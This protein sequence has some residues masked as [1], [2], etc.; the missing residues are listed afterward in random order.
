MSN[1]A[2][3]QQQRR[4]T[5]LAEPDPM[6]ATLDT[7]AMDAQPAGVQP[8]FAMVGANQG[9]HTGGDI[10]T[11]QRVAVPRNNAKIM[12]NLKALAAAAGKNYVYGWKVKDRQNN[13]E[14]WIEGPT[15]K[16]A[17]DLA[18]VYGNCMVNV[19]VV[20]AGASWM[21]Y[22]RFVD[23]ETGFTTERAYQQ[24][25][26]Q[27]VGMTDD[28][29]AA[30]MIFQIGQSKCIRN[31]I[32]NALQTYADYCVD[33]AKSSL[34]D[35]VGKEPEKARTWI[36]SKIVALGIDQKRVEAI[37]GRT[38]EHWTVP[39]MARIYTELTSIL[40]GMMTANEVYP[41][42]AADVAAEDP[43]KNAAAKTGGRQPAKKAGPDNAP[44]PGQAGGSQAQE[45]KGPGST[46]DDS[47][48]TGGT[49]GGAPIGCPIYLD[50]EDVPIAHTSDV[51]LKIGDPV[52][53]A[54]GEYMVASVGKRAA[55][56]MPVYVVKPAPA[57]E[58]KSAK[59]P[60]EPR[61]S[62]FR[63]PPKGG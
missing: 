10:I 17:N 20:D 18:R 30:D 50:L 58:E 53:A 19:R 43:A 52:H 6:R 35:S 32:V 46:P 37:Y 7:G 60:A 16:L 14:V 21:M 9:M 45:P 41:E 15:I 25:K 57:P 36:K 8:G 33:E 1:G 59:P 28:Q 62:M 3:P 42:P 5:A 27:K 49:A 47:V 29:R 55:D 38:A 12:A 40:D 26:S 22:G 56:D 63:K 23:L 31:V 24:R 2:A 11:A 48:A 13:R 34:L 44:P 39:D 4:E 54:G 51:H 61:K